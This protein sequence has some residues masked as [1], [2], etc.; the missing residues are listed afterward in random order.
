LNAGNRAA[1][2]RWAEEHENWNEAL[3]ANVLFSDESRFVLRPDSRRIR[4]WREPGQRE[5]LAHVQEV[6]SF[7]GGT[8]MVWAGISIGGRTDLI[9]LEGFLNA[10]T[11]RDRIIE[12]IVM[13]YAAAVGPNFIFM[14]DNARPHTAAII[15]E[16]LYENNIEVFD[17]PAQ[18]PDLNPIE[19]AW[20]MLERRMLALNNPPL[21]RHQLVQLVQ[22][23]QRHKFLKERLT[24]S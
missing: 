11:Y 2:L 4:V 3:W 18:S 9:F 7:E 6:H 1:R 22:N 5:R 14:H 20:D 16:S 8:V 15:Q 10:V 21:S 19:H 13:P 24:I 17:W 12:P 23:L